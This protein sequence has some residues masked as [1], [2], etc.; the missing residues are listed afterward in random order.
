[1]EITQRKRDRLSIGKSSQRAVIR[2]HR[3]NYNFQFLFR[4]RIPQNVKCRPAC[5]NPWILIYGITGTA[6]YVYCGRMPSLP[7][8]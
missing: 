1:M 6:L 7:I 5:K 8:S 3:S 2:L 4:L